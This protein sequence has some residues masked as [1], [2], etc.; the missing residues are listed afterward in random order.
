MSDDAIRLV[1]TLDRPRPE[2]PG[3]EAHDR[4]VQRARAEIVPGGIDVAETRQRIRALA[5]ELRKLPEE[6]VAFISVEDDRAGLWRIA[7][8]VLLGRL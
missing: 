3:A 2:G 4:E 1:L 8:E 5:A 7:A 6:E